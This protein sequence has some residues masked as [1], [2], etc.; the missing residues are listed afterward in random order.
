MRN[1]DNLLSWIAE[2]ERNET[3]KSPTMY[4]H[5]TSTGTMDSGTICNICLPPRRNTS[6]YS[7]Y[8]YRQVDVRKWLPSATEIIHHPYMLEMYRPRA[9]CPLKNRRTT[10]RTSNHPRPGHRKVCGRR[11]RPQHRRH[12][13]EGK[14]MRMYLSPH[15]LN[16]MDRRR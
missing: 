5:D 7:A 10:A 6:H 16:L 15:I 1:I 4:D 9:L 8:S 2:H 3:R 13:K 12:K 14:F 11:P